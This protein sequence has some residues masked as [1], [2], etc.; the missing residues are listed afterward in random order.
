M[1]VVEPVAAPELA[2]NVALPLPIAVAVPDWFTNRTVTFEEL[3]V[4]AL[5]TLVLPSSNLPTAVNA[6]VEP[7][8]S[9]GVGGETEIET[10]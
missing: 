4:T 2:D 6:W 8:T 1:T 7:V 5:S 9:D 3:Q 10:S